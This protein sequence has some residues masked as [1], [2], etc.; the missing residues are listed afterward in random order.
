MGLLRFVAFTWIGRGIA[1]L[2]VLAVVGATVVAPRFMAASPQ[3][4]LRTATVARGNV[5]QTVTVSGS[6]NASASVK[7]AFKPT[8]RI[9]EILVK[10][11]DPVTVGQPLAKLD[12]TDLAHAVRTAEANL[13]SAQAKYD[14]TAAGA[15][16]EDIALARNA[17]DSAQLNY[18]QSK[19]TTANDVT[20]AQ[21]ALDKAK[22]ALADAKVTT[23]NDVATALHALNKAKTGYASARTNFASLT[24]GI[25]TDVTAYQDALT[26]MRA[27]IAKLI[28]QIEGGTY[29]RTNDVNSARTSLISADLSLANAQTYATGSLQTALNEYLA[30]VDGVVAAAHAFDGAVAKSSDT[31][32]AASQYQTA[33]ASYQLAASRLSTAFDAPAAQV[34]GAQTSVSSAQTSLNSSVSRADYSLDPLRA[35]IVSLLSSLTAEGQLSTSLKTKV[36]QAGTNLTTIGEN[37]NGSYVSAEAAYSSAQTKAQQTLQS[38]QDAVTSAEQ[39]LATAQDKVTSTQASQDITLRNAQVNYAKSVATPKPTD[40]TSALASLQTAQA[41]LDKAKADLDAATLRAPVAG[42]IQSVANQIGEAPANPFAVIAV[43]G[44]ITLHGTIGES[45]VAKL[46]LGQV[47][48]LAVDAVGSGT[49]LTGKVTSLDPVATLQQ[50]VPVYGVDIIIDRPDPAVRPG[51]TGTATVI[52]QSKQG[53]LTVPNTAVRTSGGRRTVQV[54]RDGVAVDGGEVVFG[55]SNDTTTEVVGGLNEGD[56]VVLPAPRTTTTTPQGAGAGQIRVPGGAAPVPGGG[57]QFR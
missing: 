36:T 4:A 29:V 15:S 39:A 16:A 13:L 46:K 23:A 27:T 41:N 33:N 38:A 34:T 2:I 10:V 49:R 45:E 55:I 51:M 53:V 57:V 35:D 42:V 30:S 43:T 7:A 25:K 52:I 6:I 54:L 11:G 21:Q 47:A 28:S 12:A 20:T 22:R 50:G 9:A 32:S 44:V 18:D 5:T 17:L 26:T 19:K 14:A 3:A 8:G 40:I 24:S 48:T 31:A 1:G 56:A 37:V